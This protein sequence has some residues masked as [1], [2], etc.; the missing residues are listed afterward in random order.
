MGMQMINPDKRDIQPQG[1][2][3]CK[4]QAHQ[5]AAQ[6]TGPP[7]SADPIDRGHVHPGTVQ[8]IRAQGLDRAQM[9]PGSQLRNHP[10]EYGM[11][12]GLRGHALGNKT[13]VPD[14]GQ[15]GLVAGGLYPQ[16]K[17]NYLSSS[18]V[19]IRVASFTSVEDPINR[20]T[21]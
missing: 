15:S 9:P 5:E 20:G 4:S 14:Q 6:K 10:S 8:K 21:R 11:H 3:L 12:P 1:Q 19:I 16:A 13:A 17:H 18:E 2:T 7:G